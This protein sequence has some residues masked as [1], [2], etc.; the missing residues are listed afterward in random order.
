MPIPQEP[1]LKRLSGPFP[2][3]ISRSFDCY[4]EG[5]VLCLFMGKGIVYQKSAFLLKSHEGFARET[6][7]SAAQGNRDGESYLKFEDGR[8][9]R[10]GS[11]GCHSSTKTL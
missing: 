2:V 6:I 9:I 3:M 8:Q 1:M 11:D 10:G 5:D 7:K 4:C